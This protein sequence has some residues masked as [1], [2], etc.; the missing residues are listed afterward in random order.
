[1]TLLQLMVA[2]HSLVSQA[3]PSYSY[4]KIKK[5]KCLVNEFASACPDGMHRALLN[6]TLLTTK[7]DRIWENPPYGIFF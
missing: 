2:L 6:V 5:G 4:S 1:M 3:S 7:C